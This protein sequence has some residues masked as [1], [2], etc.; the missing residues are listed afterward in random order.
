MLT[1]WKSA[2]GM[3]IAERMTLNMSFDSQSLPSETFMPAA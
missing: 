3:M 2:R 1:S